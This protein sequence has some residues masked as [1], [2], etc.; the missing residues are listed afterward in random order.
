M[1]PI[2]DDDDDAYRC[3]V[4]TNIHFGF[5][6]EHLRE[7]VLAMLLFV[8][9]ALISLFVESGEHF[10]LVIRERDGVVVWTFRV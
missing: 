10:Q 2:F 9:K 8:V 6:C 4:G 3:I 7:R 1:W 5:S